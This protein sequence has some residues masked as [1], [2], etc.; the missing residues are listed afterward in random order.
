MNYTYRKESTDGLCAAIRAYISSQRSYFID[1]SE[2]LHPGR[3]YFHKNECLRET[4]FLYRESSK[5]MVAA[6]NIQNKNYATNMWRIA[7]DQRNR[8]WRY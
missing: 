2:F 7:F 8:T 6:I 1:I 5:R 4:R 3:V